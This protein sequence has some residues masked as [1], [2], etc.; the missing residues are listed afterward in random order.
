MTGA[1]K[2]RYFQGQMRK[3]E[4]CGIDGRGAFWIRPLSDDRIPRSHRGDALRY[5]NPASGGVVAI[6]ADC[7]SQHYFHRLHLPAR[8]E[9]RVRAGGL[10]ATRRTAPIRFSGDDSMSGFVTNVLTGGATG[11]VSAMSTVSP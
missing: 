5:G 2:S 8:G 3:N 6:D 11:A 4:R 1:W 10:P 9:P 7:A